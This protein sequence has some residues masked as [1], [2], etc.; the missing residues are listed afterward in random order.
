MVIAY[1]PEVKK[2]LKGAL[3]NP[4]FIFL[5]NPRLGGSNVMKRDEALGI[6]AKDRGVANAQVRRD[7][8]ASIIQHLTD[9]GLR[10]EL[11]DLA[12]RKSRRRP[13]GSLLSQRKPA[14]KAP[15]LP[16]PPLSN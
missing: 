10:Q 8:K 5:P 15:V 1:M 4:P 3:N 2:I 13:P 9:E 6:L 11:F 16:P 7:A 12:E 14:K